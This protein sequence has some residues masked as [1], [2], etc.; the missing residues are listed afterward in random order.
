[1]WGMAFHPASGGRGDR[2]H[3]QTRLLEPVLASSVEIQD[4]EP[5]GPGDARAAAV[6]PAGQIRVRSCDRT[7]LPTLDPPW[8]LGGW[9]PV[10]SAVTMLHPSIVKIGWHQLHTVTTVTSQLSSS[11]PACDGCP[12]L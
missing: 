11:L 9:R 1:M 4:L 10:N 7:V 3:P 5:D 12:G 2:Y 6:C 8:W